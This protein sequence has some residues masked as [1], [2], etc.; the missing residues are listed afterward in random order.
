MKRLI[1][2]ILVLFVLL[3]MAGV[4]AADSTPRFRFDSLVQVGF[5]GREAT[6]RVYL[7]NPV[8]VGRT[9]EVTLQDEDGT[10]LYTGN[11]SSG[12][13]RTLAFTV[14]DDWLGVEHL[15]IWAD[16]EKVSEKD[17]HFAA[18]DLRNK[19]IRR[20]NSSTKRMAITLDCAYG[21]L[22]TNELLD[23][24][25]EFGVKTTFFV[26]GAWVNEYPEHVKDIISRGH[27][28]GN[29]SYTHP[30]LTQKSYEITLKE[31]ARTNDLI[32]NTCGAR[33]VLFRPPFGDTNQM[34]RALSRS[35]GCEHIMWTV[36]SH[37]WD[38]EYD[39]EKIIKRVT[40][41]VEPGYI[42]LFHN[43]GRYTA[44]VL[45]TVIPYYQSLGYELVTVSSLLS[46]D[47]YIVD[48]DGIVQFSSR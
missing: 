2:G 42:I 28:I 34:V 15:S 37:D 11:F 30:R 14:P 47:A 18:D 6:A 16:G 44:D 3:G 23:I 8:S 17:M 19:A 46:E 5:H 21:D 13:V 41:T 12:K 24:L 9:V 40:K 29:H 4:A 45:R 31:I 25:D 7:V 32:E 35:V 39:M 20:V 36:D 10:V 27:E 22:H 48:A 26:I 33:P 38:N 1:T 43:D